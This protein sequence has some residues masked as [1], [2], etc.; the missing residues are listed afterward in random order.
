MIMQRIKVLFLD[1]DGTINQDTGS[2]ISSKEQL[3][4][5]DRADEAIALA[6]SA[7]F[8]I[9]IVSNQA[10]IARGIATREQVEE[11]NRYL[12]ALLSAKGAGF[13]RCYYCPFHPEYPHPEYDR[14]ADFRK[15]A[16]G[17]VEQAINEFLEEGLIVD[18]KAS[19]FVG[20]KTLDVECALRAGLRPLLVRTGHNEE[21]L[22]VERNII[23]EYVADDLYHAVTEHIL[24]SS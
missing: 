21:K 23:P 4:L 12:N 15:P 16:T 3:V 1:R 20:D 17:M 5:I 14:F 18:R 19:F 11:V 9:V 7:G 10:G 6:K 2:Y 24:A 8:R 22:C 13:D